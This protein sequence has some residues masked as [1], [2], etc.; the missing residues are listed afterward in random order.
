M[1]KPHYFEHLEMLQDSKV[2]P[3]LGR[4][5]YELQVLRAETERLRDLLQAAGADA[6]RYRWLRDKA[7]VWTDGP[8][9]P[10]HQAELC[11]LWVKVRKDVDGAID[12]AIKREGPW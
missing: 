12:A 3:K 5:F 4:V 1:T 7:Y 6:W 9:Y 10:E 8:V 11:A 2:D